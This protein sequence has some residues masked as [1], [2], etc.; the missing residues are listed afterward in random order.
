MLIRKEVPKDYLDIEKLLCNT[1]GSSKEADSMAQRRV[2]KTYAPEL[3]LIGLKDDQLISHIHYSIVDVNGKKGLSIS[4]VTVKKEFQRKGYGSKLLWYTLRK[5]K[6]L[7]YDF[8]VALG[9][10]EF[11]RHFHFEKAKK[12]NIHSDLSPA[13]EY[14]ILP[15]KKGI[16]D[17][18]EGF[19][20]Y[21]Y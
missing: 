14:L 8:V 4:P 2:K 18:V 3:C 16:L 11:F 21:K 9:K 6:E 15:L 13:E 19:I 12:Y 20:S 5:A 17:K 1:F 10:E 7:G